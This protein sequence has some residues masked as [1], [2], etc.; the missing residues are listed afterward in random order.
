MPYDNILVEVKGCASLRHALI[1]LNRPRQLNALNDAP[2]D[3]LGEALRGFDA[4]ESIGCIV[5][6]GNEKA[7]AAGADILAT[8]FPFRQRT[9]ASA[10]WQRGSTTLLS[11]FLAYVRNKKPALRIGK[12]MSHRAVRCSG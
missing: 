4:D 12:R 10:Q 11:G 2:I 6:T 9:P 8:S 3:E 5:I 1:R 7:F